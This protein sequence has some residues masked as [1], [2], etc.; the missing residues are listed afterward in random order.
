MILKNLECEILHTQEQI[1]LIDISKLKQL[2]PTLK[3][4]E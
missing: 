3:S 4:L 2:S 1:K